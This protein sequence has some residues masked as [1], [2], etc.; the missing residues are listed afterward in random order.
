MFVQYVYIVFI[1]ILNIEK[2]EIMIV[3]VIVYVFVFVGC[4]DQPGGVPA[5]QL[6]CGSGSD[7]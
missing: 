3:I 5:R 7:Q 2:R 4:R 6:W 1:F